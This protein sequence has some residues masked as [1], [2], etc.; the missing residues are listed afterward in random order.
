MAQSATPSRNKVLPQ[1]LPDADLA[2]FQRIA[3]EMTGIKLDDAKRSMIYTRFLRRLRTLQMTTFDQ[4]LQHVQ[5]GAS[6]EVEEFINTITTNL[7]YFFREPHHFEF[8][9]SDVVPDLFHK[10]GRA[11]A[12]R[13]WSAGCSSGEE[14]YS[15]ALSLAEEGLTGAA[16][17]R[18][19]CTDIDTEMVGATRAGE[20]KLSNVRGLDD[21]LRSRWFKDDGNGTLLANDALRQGMMCK[22]LNLFGNWPVRPGIDIIFCRNVLIYFEKPHQEQIING[23]AQKQNPG[24]YMFLGHSESLRGFDHLYERVANTVYKRV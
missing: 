1:S 2:A 21:S 10:P 11:G 9:R 4:Y 13:V 24:A 15:I 3:M 16:D 6:E 18:L 17:Y 12:V 7:T 23:F 8:L 5:S 14:P 20:F 22:Q 19:L